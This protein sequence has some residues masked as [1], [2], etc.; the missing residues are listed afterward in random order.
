LN[1]AVEEKH[2]ANLEF[3]FITRG[4]NTQTILKT[5]MRMQITLEGRFV[6]LKRPSNPKKIM[7]V[8]KSDFAATSTGPCFAKQQLGWWIL[9]WKTR[10][11]DWNVV[12]R[13]GIFYCIYL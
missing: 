10:P 8:N 13:S 1:S 9:S 6:L 4:L 5:S 3:L 11:A 7:Q 12:E 2:E